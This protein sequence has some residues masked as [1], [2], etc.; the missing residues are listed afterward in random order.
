VASFEGAQ[1][2]LLQ[3]WRARLGG[4]RPVADN[5]A[6]LSRDARVTAL[7]LGRMLQQAWVSPVMPEL[8]SSLPIGHR[9][10]LASQQEQSGAAHLKTGSLRDVMA[11]AGFVHAASGR[12]YVLVAI[13][14]HPSAAARGRCSMHWWTGRHGISNPLNLD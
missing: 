9:R 12:R 3:W 6:G 14:N 8:V 5:G 11:V 4:W 1:E 2:V 13:V 10:H 7:G